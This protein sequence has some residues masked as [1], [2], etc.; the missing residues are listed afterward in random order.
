MFPYN[1][2]M[3]GFERQEALLREAEHE[4]LMRAARGQ[5]SNN[6]RFH[7]KSANWL[8]AQMVKWGQRLEQFGTFDEACPSA[9]VSPRP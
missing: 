8:G 9:S 5:Q 1:N 3:L 6:R 4:R 7:R 2:Y